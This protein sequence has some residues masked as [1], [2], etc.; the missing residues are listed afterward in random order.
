MASTR[1][2][3]RLPDRPDLVREL[4]SRLKGYLLRHEALIPREN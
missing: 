1:V 4:E 2:F 3:S